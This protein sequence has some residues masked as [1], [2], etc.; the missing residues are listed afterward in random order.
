MAYVFYK[1]PFQKHALNR[2]NPHLGKAFNA[3][4]LLSKSQFI[5]L[6]HMIIYNR[7]LTDGKGVL[8]STREVA[9]RVRLDP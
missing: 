1:T 7:G 2:N 9:V 6:C 4:K 3:P 5:K 8:W